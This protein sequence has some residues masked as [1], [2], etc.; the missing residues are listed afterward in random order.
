MFVDC[1][2]IHDHPIDG[3]HWWYIIFLSIY[4]IVLIWYQL[5]IYIYVIIYIY[6][7]Y[8]NIYDLYSYIYIYSYLFIS[9][10]I[11][12]YITLDF[13]AIFHDTGGSPP[14]P[15][16]CC[17]RS[18]PWPPP[19]PTWPLWAAATPRHGGRFDGKNVGKIW[20]VCHEKLE[21]LM[22][23]HGIMMG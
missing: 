6:I 15:P 1:I 19:A 3:T 2:I 18:G 11:Y 16:R 4:D 8:M 14:G 12:I 7:W 13:P 9:I 20:G 17:H 23:F 22:E 10:H 5:Y 21:F